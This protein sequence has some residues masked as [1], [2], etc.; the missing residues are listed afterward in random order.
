MNIL[1][2]ILLVLLFL[3]LWLGFWRGLVKT[4][5]AIIGLIAGIFLAGIFYTD[6]VAWITQYVSWSESVLNVIVFILILIIAGRIADF[7]LN[8]LF[9]FVSFLPF[10]KTINRLA[11]AAFGLV[12]GVIILGL[13]LF[14]YSKYPF[15]E[16]LDSVIIDSQVAPALT[17]LIKFAL[18]LLPSALKEIEGLI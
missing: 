15:W 3:S 5:S 7:I 17:F 4:L 16:A 14:I 12:Q 11:G 1:D 18:L 8:G 2:I 6:V 9:K 10:I 13:V